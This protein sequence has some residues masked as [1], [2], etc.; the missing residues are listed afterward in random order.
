[1]RFLRYPGGKGKL[2]SFL[3]NYL[4]KCDK[5]KG[6][7]IEPF[8]GGGS[9]FLFMQPQK[10]V[11]SDL[12]KDLIDLYQGIRNYPHKVWE[13]FES[14]PRGKKTY[15]KIRDDNFEKKPLY[16]RAARIL[17]LNRTCFKGMWRHNPNGDF[18]VG[19]GGEARRWVIT[20]QNITDL[21]KRFKKAD[22]LQSDFENILDNTSNGDF[23]F[24]DPP[25]KPGER[26]MHHAH[27]ING[28]FSF[29]DQKRL[30]NKI[31]EVSKIK[32]IKWLMTNSSNPEICRLYKDFN[33][34]KI[35]KGTSN[36]VGVFSNNS[37]EVL[38][39]NY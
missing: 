29:D 39:S 23:I 8:V 28:K 26:E 5:I 4:P 32:S 14:F 11:I 24:I 30:A 18:N 21:S 25:Y 31:K 37:N 19:Y 22:I 10:A 7:Y 27:Y 16:Y 34:V 15:Y 2:L 36:V 38:I 12:N 33:I 17:Y 9:V 35:P 3:V 20:H 6:K 1:M 13:I